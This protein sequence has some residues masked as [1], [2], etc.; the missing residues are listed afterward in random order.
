[1]SIATKMALD[2]L[3]VAVEPLAVTV[4]LASLDAVG[5]G[6][7]MTEVAASCIGVCLIVCS[8]CCCCAD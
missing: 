2:L 1:M 7:G 4:P 5:I 8:C 3:D 6:H